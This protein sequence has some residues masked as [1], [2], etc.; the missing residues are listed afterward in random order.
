MCSVTFSVPALYAGCW[1]LL[2]IPIFC[3]QGIFFLFLQGYRKRYWE[4]LFILELNQILVMW[5]PFSL[6]CFSKLNLLSIRLNLLKFAEQSLQHKSKKTLLIC[7]G[8]NSEIRCKVVWKVRTT[9]VAAIVTV[10]TSLFQL[11]IVFFI[12]FVNWHWWTIVQ[13]SLGLCMV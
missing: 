10:Q 4:L 11:T 1:F 6:R 8:Y 9:N 7:T 3:A 13:S 12:T 2:K 5:Q